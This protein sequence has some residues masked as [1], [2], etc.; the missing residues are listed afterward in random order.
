MRFG[1]DGGLW[2]LKGTELRRIQSH[3]VIG[4]PAAVPAG[5]R[6]QLAAHPTPSAGPVTLEFRLAE[7]GPAALEIFDVV[8]RRIRL[9][10][11]DSARAAGPQR[12]AWDGRDDAGNRAR[13]GVYLARLR[14]GADQA[15][16]RLVLV[17]PG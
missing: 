17:P 2:Y 11:D 16:R 15:T 10:A 14:C 13:P 9:L 1:R 5:A 8:G 6:L 12:I 3:A 7:A 4:V